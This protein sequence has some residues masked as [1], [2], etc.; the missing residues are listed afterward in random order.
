MPGDRRGGMLRQ[1][2]SLAEDNFPVLPLPVAVHPPPIAFVPM[3]PQRPPAELMMHAVIH[4]SKDSLG[5][6]VGVVPRPAC[7]DRPEGLNQG[8]LAGTAIPSDHS[9]R[10]SEVTVLRLPA[11]LDQR[12]KAE[13]GAHTILPAAMAAHGIL[14]DV[15][16][17]KIASHL[18]LV[19]MQ[20]MGDARFAGFEAQ[21]NLLEPLCGAGLEGKE[22][23]QVA[24]ED[25]GVVG[26]AYHRW[27]P[28][29]A[30]FPAW[31]TATQRFFEPVEGYIGQQ[32]GR[33]TPLRDSGPC[34]GEDSPMQDPSLQP[35]LDEASQRAER[36][37]FAKKSGMIDLVEALFDVSL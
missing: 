3:A 28:R 26:I 24:M 13:G 37:E 6:D 12:F 2:L 8:L 30:F 4:H 23:V 1:C 9:A 22:R 15:E 20:G 5:D 32:R 34:W 29:A 7:N 27:L 18:A 25:E 35:A 17:E 19:G 33:G 14:A 31:D 11:G 10:A 16:S 21:T 36:V